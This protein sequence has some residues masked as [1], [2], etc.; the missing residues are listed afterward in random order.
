MA[1]KRSSALT[2]KR[3]EVSEMARNA[4]LEAMIRDLEALADALSQQ[5][6]AEEKRTKIKDSARADYSM[7]AKAAMARRSKLI[8]SLADLRSR[9]ATG[10]REHV[11]AARV[12]RDLEMAPGGRAEEANVAQAKHVDV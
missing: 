3:F 9:L 10:K 11:E 12:L 5:I 1:K 2:A 4:S 7:V 8:T 6:L